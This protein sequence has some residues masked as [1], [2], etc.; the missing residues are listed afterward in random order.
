MFES[1]I[2]IG[3]GIAGLS[4][5]C[6]GQMNGYQTR[7]FELH[8]KPG[9]VC[10]SWKRKDYTV[11]GCIHWLIGSAKDSSLYHIWEELGAVQ[12]RQFVNFDEFSR[13]EDEH[14]KAF[15][16]YA[17]LD[18]LEKHMLELAPADKTTTE[19]FIGGARR[20][21]RYVW[22]ADKSPDLYIILSTH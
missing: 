18:A 10:T 7:I 5:G 16:V 13:V 14:G 12:G 6:Y 4:A 9:G 17:N 19:K 11:D 8:D 1:I 2:I 21:T 22:E 15:S 3:A 20:L